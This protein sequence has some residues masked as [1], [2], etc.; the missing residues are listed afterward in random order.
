MN[1]QCSHR[2]ETSQLMR[3]R[4]SEREDRETERDIYIYIYI[5]LYN[6]Q[7]QRFTDVAQNSSFFKE[8]AH[9]SFQNSF[10]T[11]HF[12]P[13]ASVNNTPIVVV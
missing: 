4:E 3:N 9:L 13:T 5:C 6:I 2:V 12:H 11:E 10:F 8:R 1:E 7:E